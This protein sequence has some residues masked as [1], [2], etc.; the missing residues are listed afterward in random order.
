MP[1]IVARAVA[2]RVGT[3]GRRHGWFDVRHG[4]ALLRSREVPVGKKAAALAIGLVVTGLLYLFEIPMEAVLGVLLP[5]LGL[6]FD[7]A[8]DGLELV[9]L[10]ILFACLVLNG[11]DRRAAIGR[12]QG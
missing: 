8:V 6:G 3:H 9:I 11:G 5:F 1:N 10:P 7:L 4:F 2:N 12:T